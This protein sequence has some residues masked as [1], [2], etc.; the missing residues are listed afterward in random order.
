MKED[1]KKLN[2]RQL[3]WYGDP[4]TILT[5]P[6]GWDVRK[7]SMAGEDQKEL[8][9]ESIRERLSRPYGCLPL[10]QIARGKKEAVILFDDL[11]RP[12]PAHRLIP[13]ILEDL[14][15][16]GIGKDHI[17]F[18]AAIG[19]HRPMSGQELIRKLGE[20]VV[21]R[22]P[23][24][25][26]NPYEGNKLLGRTR[27]G[28]PVKVN[29]EVASCDLKIGIGCIIPHSFYQFGGG[30]KIILPGVSSYPS[31]FYN[32]FHVAGLDGKGPVSKEAGQRVREDMEEAGR[33][34][35][36]DMVVDCLVNGRREI[37]DL[38]A[39]DVG[40]AFRAGCEKA[41]KIYVSPLIQGVDVAMVNT[42][43]IESEPPKSRKLAVMSIREG[44]DI[45]FIAD[46]V[47][48]SITHY[49]FGRFGKNYGGKLWKAFHQ[50]KIGQAARVIVFS[51]R[52]FQFD[53]ESYGPKEKTLWISN[54]EEVIAELKKA[55]GP[56]PKVAIYPYAPL[57]MLGG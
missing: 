23:V 42:Y 18:V 29:R 46:S 36:I 19:N 55:H 31:T 12:T 21:A 26:H 48:G 38:F 5:F 24:Y 50:P 32:H 56:K 41:K 3:A 39:G 1:F 7:S 30:A 40:E 44:G 51:P 43:P 9:G 35:G 4:E 6:E 20:G 13:F 11:T 15:K 37:I 47:E 52:R 28:T 34:V 25:N 45:V 54:W 16:G 22:F 53:T 33:I 49:L 10:D 8:T 2:I 57:Q 27:H 17:R 14:E